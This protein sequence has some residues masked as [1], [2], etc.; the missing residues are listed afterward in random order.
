MVQKINIY[1][2]SVKFFAC[3]CDCKESRRFLIP[4][5]LLG[6]VL[7]TLNGLTQSIHTRCRGFMRLNVCSSSA[8]KNNSIHAMLRKNGKAVKNMLKKKNQRFENQRATLF[9]VFPIHTWLFK[10]EFSEMSALAGVFKSRRFQWLLL[11]LHEFQWAGT[12]PCTYS[13]YS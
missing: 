5:A 9:S 2:K 7:D 13:H 12:S 6:M 8:F 10:P 1:L 4:L 11:V 3:V